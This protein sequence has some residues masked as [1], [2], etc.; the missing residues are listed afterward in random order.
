MAQRNRRR[1]RRQSGEPPMPDHM[2]GVSDETWEL[3]QAHEY[4]RRAALAAAR[5]H[6]E[7]ELAR[8]REETLSNLSITAVATF[9]FG[10]IAVALFSMGF[11]GW[12]LLPAALLVPTFALALLF[13]WRLLRPENEGRTSG[14]GRSGSGA[15][16]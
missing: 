6:V 9:A 2:E 3:L 13:A 12:G 1:L 8:P 14:P 15:P 4:T 16:G 7:A 5:R 10:V 11:W